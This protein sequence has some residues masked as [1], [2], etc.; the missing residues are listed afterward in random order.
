MLFLQKLFDEWAVRR[1]KNLRGPN[2]PAISGGT[3]VNPLRSHSPSL[4][5]SQRLK[6]KHVGRDHLRDDVP[7]FRGACVRKIR[8]EL[9]RCHAACHHV[10][11]YTRMYRCSHPMQEAIFAAFRVND[12]TATFQ[13][14]DHSTA[15]V[16]FT[17]RGW[18]PQN[19]SGRGALPG[20]PDPSVV[21][22]DF[23]IDFVGP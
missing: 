8:N 16:M 12:H 7:Y 4:R 15:I 13:Q 10:S 2:I 19:L 1:T 22:V 21:F 6:S 5:V 20:A 17:W 3:D 9:I 14:M 18:L 11:L 23:P